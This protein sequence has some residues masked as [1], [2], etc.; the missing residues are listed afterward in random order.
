MPDD[1]LLKEILNQIK[2]ASDKIIRRIEN[3]KSPDDF[4]LTDESLDKL[5]AICMAL[6]AIGESLKKVDKLTEGKLLEKYPAVDWKGLKG[7]RDIISHQYFD[8]NEEAVFTTCKKD[9]PVLKHTLIE[10]I[11]VYK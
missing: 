7:I 11:K 2:D 1:P 8:L 9:I 10:I 3:I 6:I 5:D 4:Y